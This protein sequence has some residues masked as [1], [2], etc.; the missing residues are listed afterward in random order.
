MFYTLLARAVL[1]GAASGTYLGNIQVAREQSPVDV[2]SV[3]DIRVVVFY[4]SLLQHLLHKI[5]AVARFL[6][7]QLDNGCQYL[8]LSLVS[9]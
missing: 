4:S 6:Q 7:E 3:A 1:V 9:R 2:C 8:Q 5:L